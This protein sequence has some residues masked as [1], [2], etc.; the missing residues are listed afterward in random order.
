LKPLGFIPSTAD[1]CIF[2]NGDILLA[3][4]VDDLVLVGPSKEV[5]KIKQQLMEKFE[6]RD[7]GD[8]SFILGLQVE[9]TPEKLEIHQGKYIKN[10]LES[11]GM[12]DC[13]PVPT[14]IESNKTDD[15]PKLSSNIP[16]TRAVGEL[17]YIVTCTRSDIS[18]AVWNV[19]KQMHAPTARLDCSETYFQ[20]LERYNGS[21]IDLLQNVSFGRIL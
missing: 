15:S 6:M 9:M 13:R 14:P 5:M 17:N 21:E 20:I 8:L 7:L 16:Y 19:S 18:F 2:I 12:I 1:Q 3:I 4:Y 11:H 10:V